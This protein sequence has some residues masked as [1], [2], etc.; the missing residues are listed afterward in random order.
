MEDSRQLDLAAV[1]RLCRL[2]GKKFAREMIEL[3]VDFAGKKVAEAQRAVWVGDLA[4]VQKAVHPMKSSAGNVGAMRVQELATRL[5][6]EAQNGDAERVLASLSELEQ[7]LKAA[8]LQ[9]NVVKQVLADP[10][11]TPS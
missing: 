11:A 1:E 3:F 7:A 2:G 8:H 10:A 5:E 9:L 4:A 6:S